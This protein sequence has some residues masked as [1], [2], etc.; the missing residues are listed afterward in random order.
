MQQRT[1]GVS[2]L[3]VSVQRSKGPDRPDTKEKT[4]RGGDGAARAG[5]SGRGSQDRGCAVGT[6]QGPSARRSGVA[7]GTARSPRGEMVLAGGLR[8]RG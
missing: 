1:R 5:G 4:Q 2:G 8:S 7:G 6:A 3:R